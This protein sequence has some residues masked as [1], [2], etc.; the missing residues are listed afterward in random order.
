M[1]ALLCGMHHGDASQRAGACSAAFSARPLSIPERVSPPERDFAHLRIAG[2]I[3]CRTTCR[4]NVGRRRSEAW[5]LGPQPDPHGWPPC[6]LLAC[7]AHGFRFLAG[8][9][10]GG[11]LVGATLLHLAEDALALHR[12]FQ[13]SESLI[14]VVVTNKYLQRMGPLLAGVNGSEGLEGRRLSAIRRHALCSHPIR[15]ISDYSAEWSPAIS[16]HISAPLICPV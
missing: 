8:F 4:A 1:G 5:A 13:P 12:R 3:H 6:G 14:D 16:R 15:R 10:L 9:A 7:P 11:L 2:G